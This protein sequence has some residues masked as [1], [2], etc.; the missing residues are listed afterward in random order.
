MPSSQSTGQTKAA[1]NQKAAD[2]ESDGHQCRSHIASAEGNNTP[3]SLGH[4]P[5]NAKHHPAAA[6]KRQPPSAS[7]KIYRGEIGALQLAHF[8]RSASHERIGIFCHHLIGELHFGQCDGGDT[9]DSPLG[10]RQIT[11]FRNEA[12]Q[13]PSPKLKTARI[14]AMFLIMYDVSFMSLTL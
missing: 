6:R 1:Q 12:M 4:G 11:T 9:I 8:P 3:D 13:A 5:N 14:G 10:A 7:T 2:R